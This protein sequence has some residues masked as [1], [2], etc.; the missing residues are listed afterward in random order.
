[1][2]QTRMR[3]ALAVTALC[4]GPVA[5]DEQVHWGYAGKHV[6]AHWGEVAPTCQIGQQQSPVNIQTQ[7]AKKGTLPALAVHWDKATGEVVNNGHSIQVNL[8]PGSYLELDGTRYELAQFHFHTPSEHQLNGKAWPLEIHFVHHTAEG[9]LAVV[10][11]LVKTGAENAA[12]KALFGNLPATQEVKNQLEVDP[13]ALLPAKLEYFTY[14][15]SLTTPPC[16]EGVHWMVVEGP[17]A[18]SKAQVEA[19]RKLFPQNARPIQPLHAR[20]I[21]L[22]GAAAH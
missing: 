7:R 14:E 1:M 4:T 8:P 3:L 11:V 6:L 20:A 9:K 16:S 5:A 22:E 17:I 18:A 2:Q 13:T 19:F 10:G 12:L 21:E 15:G